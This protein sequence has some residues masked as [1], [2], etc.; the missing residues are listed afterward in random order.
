MFKMNYYTEGRCSNPSHPNCELSGA[1]D[2]S[3]A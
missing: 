3:V 2:K 1:W